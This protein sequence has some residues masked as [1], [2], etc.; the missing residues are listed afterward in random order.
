MLFARQATIIGFVENAQALLSRIA[1]RCS[2]HLTLES[3]IP[4][5]RAAEQINEN[6][7]VALA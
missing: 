2:I 5:M 3:W 4:W 1:D 7:Q 6:L